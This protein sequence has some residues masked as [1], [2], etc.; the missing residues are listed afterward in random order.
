MDRLFG[1]DTALY[2]DKELYDNDIALT[3]HPQHESSTVEGRYF[4]FGSQPGSGNERRFLFAHAV[5]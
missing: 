1:Y 5:A 4:S 2:G 3:E